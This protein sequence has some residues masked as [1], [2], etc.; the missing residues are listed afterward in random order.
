MTKI[1]M[2]HLRAEICDAEL[3]EWRMILDTNAFDPAR[4][5]ARLVG[6]IYRDKH[7]RFHDGHG[8]LTSPLRT[9]L[10][11]VVSGAIVRTQRTRYRLLS[12]K[13]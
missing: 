7:K 1:A 10:H 8:V 9:H 2:S 12:P 5:E 6:R 3:D 11:R 13:F 4:T